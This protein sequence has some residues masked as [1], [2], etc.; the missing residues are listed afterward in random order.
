M[1]VSVGGA[2]QPR[3]SS[4]IMGNAWGLGRVF[5]AQAINYTAFGFG[6]RGGNGMFRISDQGH[7]KADGFFDGKKII[8]TGAA[9]TVGT[10]LV[11]WLLRTTAAEVRGIDSYEHGLFVLA[12][13]LRHESR[14]HPFICDVRNARKLSTMFRHMDYCI[15]TAALK[16][17]GSS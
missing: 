4:A 15:H 7:D 13:A 5:S 6:Q 12:E 11:K 8:I 3:R 1:V 14:F 9:G 2:C 16:H 10:E 17:V